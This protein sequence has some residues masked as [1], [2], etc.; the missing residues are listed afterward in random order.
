VLQYSRS[1]HKKHVNLYVI[2]DNNCVF[3][4]VTKQL[5]VLVDDVNDNT[6]QFNATLYTFNVS[7]N[8]VQIIGQLSVSKKI[9]TKYVCPHLCIY[10]PY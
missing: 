9:N 4:T 3:Q 1:S 6:P 5:S 7:E 2:T 10:T 8:D